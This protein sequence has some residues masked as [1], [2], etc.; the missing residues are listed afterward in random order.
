[1]HGHICRSSV[2]YTL[3]ARLSLHGSSLFLH[4]DETNWVALYS[5]TAPNTSAGSYQE[6]ALNDF[7][8]YTSYVFKGLT[9]R[10]E[11]RANTGL[12]N[13]QFY[14]RENG[15]VQTL[16]R[17]AGITDKYYTAMAQLLADTTTLTAVINSNSAID[18][19]ATAKA[20]ISS[21]CNDETAMGLIGNNNYAANT[22]L[23]DDSWSGR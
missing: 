7:G 15:G 22:L 4:N 3:S 17:A 20:F 18:Y 23:A 8:N 6:S 16:L 1:M 5:A 2:A 10:P 9:A 14:G 19:L 12:V 11:Q 21:I 13:L